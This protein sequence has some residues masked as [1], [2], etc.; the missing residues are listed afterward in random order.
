MVISTDGIAPDI[1]TVF[2]CCTRI[3]MT[4]GIHMHGAYYVVQ[5]LKSQ[6]ERHLVDWTLAASTTD[7]NAVDAISLLGLVS[8]TTSLVRAGWAGSTVH[9]RHLPELPGT[10]TLEEAHHIGL[11]AVP[12]FTEVFVSSHCCL[13]EK[14]RTQG[15]INHEK[16]P[17]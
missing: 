16:K 12:K 10:D 9:G 7:A 11:L 15:L 6:Y 2:L 5:L 8:K 13:L 14:L 4:T 17:N 3:D 1:G